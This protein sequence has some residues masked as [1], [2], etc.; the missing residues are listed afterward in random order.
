[1]GEKGAVFEVWDY[2]LVS[3]LR[4]ETNREDA[5][6]AKEE[7]GREDKELRNPCPYL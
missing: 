7:N 3:N 6:Y 1:L 2:L 5:K 4:I